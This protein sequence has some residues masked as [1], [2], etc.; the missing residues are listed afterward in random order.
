MKFGF[1]ILNEKMH[2]KKL[3]ITFLVTICAV[4]TILAVQTF[5]LQPIEET[6]RCTEK[7]TATVVDMEIC[8]DTSYDRSFSRRYWKTNTYKSYKYTYQFDYNGTTVSGYDYRNTGYGVE[9]YSIGDEVAIR[10]NPNNPE[11]FMVEPNTFDYVLMLVPIVIALAGIW[12]FHDH[13]G[14]FKKSYNINA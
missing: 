4:M 10:V 9:C 8:I 13:K 11:E 12:V 3:A 6:K 2:S 1:S 7:V 5:I 14:L